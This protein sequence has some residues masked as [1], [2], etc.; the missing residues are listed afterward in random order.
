MIGGTQGSVADLFSGILIAAGRSGHGREEGQIDIFA[1]DLRRAGRDAFGRSF[2][3]AEHVAADHVSS[4]LKINQYIN[5]LYL[6]PFLSLLEGKM[7]LR[8]IFQPASINQNQD[9]CSIMLFILFSLLYFIWTSLP[10]IS[11]TNLVFPWS[12]SIF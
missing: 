2:S 3:V 12:W 11:F 6:Y 5:P 9:Y 8:R 10:R 7:D 1:L 4:L